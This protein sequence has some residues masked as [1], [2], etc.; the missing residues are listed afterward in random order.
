VGGCFDVYEFF[1][2]RTTLVSTA[3]GAGS[4][5]ANAFLRGISDD[6]TRVFFESREK[7]DPSDP[8]ELN[9]AFVSMDYYPYAKAATPMLISLVSAQQPCTAPNREHAPPLAFG[10]CSPAAPLSSRVEWGT[11]DANGASANGTGSI[12]LRALASGDMAIDAQVTDVR[13]RV[14]LEHC[15]AANLSGGGDYTGELA[16]VLPVRLTD[17]RAGPLETE[18]ATLPDFD[19]P[20]PLACSST[21]GDLEGSA[22]STATTLNALIPGAAVAGSRAT[23]AFDSLRV[24]DGGA[25]GQAATAPNETFLTQGV[26]AP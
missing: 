19:I 5:A 20:F 8:D 26:F 4:G 15:G 3:P 1:N 24:A 25:D 21:A 6:G 18:Q 16:G 23:L 9:D 11:P 17:R 10:S 7:L 14:A 22:C 12:R 13:C 2:G